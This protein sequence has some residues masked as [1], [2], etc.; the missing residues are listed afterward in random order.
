MLPILSDLTLR[1]HVRA[2]LP[3]WSRLP[4][5]AVE[6]TRLLPSRSPDHGD[7]GTDAAMLAAHLAGVPGAVF[8]ARLAERLTGPYQV[9]VAGPGFINLTFSQDALDGILPGLL[10]SVLGS[11]PPPRATSMTLPLATMCH[12]D[13]DFMVQYAHARCHSVLRAAADMPGLGGHDPAFLAGAARGWFVA[14]PSRVLLCRLEHWTRL[15]GTPGS[16]PDLRR[17]MLFLRDLGQQFEHLW[18]ASREHA[19]LRLLYPAERSRSLANVALVLA[20]AGVI[21]SGLELLEVGAAE[22]IR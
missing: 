13:A 7:I 4:D 1:E 18:K 8:A 17:I 5:A 11:P 2:L 9:R 15:A 19:T 16:P 3:E 10:G 20:T 6:R 21:R 12:L 22:E 14:G